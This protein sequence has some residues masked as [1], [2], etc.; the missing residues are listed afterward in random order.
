V[1][2]HPLTGIG[3]DN[4]RLAY[5]SYAGLSGVDVRLH[6]NNMY[7][8]MLAGGGLLVGCAFG[9]LVWR[10][11]GCAAAL[12]RCTER[13]CAIAFG[14]AAALLAIAL[15]A[16]VDSFLSF[17]PI[18]VLFSLTLGSAVA[19]ARGVESHAHRL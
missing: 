15:H 1:A 5:G 13:H 7:L 3:P 4:F 9:W 14:L 18:Y 11:A 17:A 16:T 10:A 12:A 6:S 2:A 19:C 8:E